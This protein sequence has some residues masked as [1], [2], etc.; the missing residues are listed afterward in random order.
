VT[1]LTST[2]VARNTWWSSFIEGNSVTL[3]YL[4][5]PVFAEGGNDSFLDGPPTCAAD[6]NT[7]LVVAPEAVQLVLEH[8]IENVY[9]H[10]L[11]PHASLA[12]H[13][14]GYSKVN[15]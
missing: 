11:L 2:E 14:S 5:V 1:K 4:D 8:G 3:A 15:F 9:K 13:K 12:L 10:S 7:H 6:G